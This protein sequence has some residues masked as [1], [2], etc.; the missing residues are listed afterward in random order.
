MSSSQTFQAAIEMMQPIYTAAVIHLIAELRGAQWC[1]LYTSVIYGREIDLLSVPDYVEDARYG[2]SILCIRAR[3]SRPR[4]EVFV[5]SARTGVTTCGPWTA[6]KS[7]ESSPVGRTR[8]SVVSGSQSLC[9][10]GA[11]QLWK[12]DR[13]F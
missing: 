7:A 13:V 9:G 4:A 6:G 12:D 3:V 1:N 10:Q 8:I 5:T 2:A 11:K